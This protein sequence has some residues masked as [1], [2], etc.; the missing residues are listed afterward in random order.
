MRHSAWID[1]LRLVTARQRHN[2]MVMTSGPAEIAIHEILRLEEEYLV[3]RGR[4]GGTNN[5]GRIFFVPYDQLIY[6]GLQKPV[7]PADVAAL[8]DPSLPVEVPSPPESAEAAAEPPEETEAAGD[9]E[10]AAPSATPHETPTASPKRAE[11]LER[12][13][14]RKQNGMPRRL[15]PKA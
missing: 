14:A 8:Y 1:L 5:E 11:L 6:V 3:I 2:M 12:I 4:L 15:P 9:P 7:R 10:P 13:R